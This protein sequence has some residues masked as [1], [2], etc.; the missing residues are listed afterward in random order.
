MIYLSKEH[1]GT[2]LEWLELRGLSFDLAKDLPQ[3]G[4]VA[5][6]ETQPIAMAFLRICEGDMA[7]IDGLISNPVASSADRHVALD[8]VISELI[9]EA[10]TLGIKSLLAYSIDEG[11]IKRA[12]RQGFETKPNILLGMK[13]GE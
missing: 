8:E 10:K 3:I 12:C 4:Y 2:L 9:K 11:T 13:L 1:L 6:K 7:M 5:F